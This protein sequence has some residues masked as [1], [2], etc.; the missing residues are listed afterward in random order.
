MNDVSLPHGGGFGHGDF[1]IRNLVNLDILI[2]SV[3]KRTCI[4]MEK[5][6]EFK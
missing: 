5:T 6:T 2:L 3:K 1:V 4:N